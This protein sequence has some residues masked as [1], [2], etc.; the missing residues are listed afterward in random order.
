MVPSGK[1]DITFQDDV[2]DP[3]LTQEIAQRQPRLAAANDD[4]VNVLP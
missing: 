3:C 1:G 2:A 4:D